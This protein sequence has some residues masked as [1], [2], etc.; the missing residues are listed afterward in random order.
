[1]VD[2]K[3]VVDFVDDPAEELFIEGL[4]EGVPDVEDLVFCAR[5]DDS[6]TWEGCTY[7]GPRLKSRFFVEDIFKLVFLCQNCCIKNLL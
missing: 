3:R 6:L 2:A 5:Y 4:G 7:W 1:M